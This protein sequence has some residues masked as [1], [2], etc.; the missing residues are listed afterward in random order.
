MHWSY[1][2]LASIYSINIC[3]IEIGI[4][5]PGLLQIQSSAVTTWSNIVRYYINNYRNWSRTSIRC[6]IYRRHPPKSPL[7]LLWRHNEHH[8]VSIHQP[9]DCLLKRLFRHRSKKTLKLRVIGLCARNSPGA[10]EFPAQ[11]ASYAEDVSIWWR[12]YVK[13]EALVL[14]YHRVSASTI[15]TTPDLGSRKLQF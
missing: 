8:D 9:H 7:S 1:C 3:A 5:T 12:H 14:T 10:G 15:W 2:S 4:T 13:G 11:M 6:W